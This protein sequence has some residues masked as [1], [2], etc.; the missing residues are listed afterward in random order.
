MT[1]KISCSISL[2]ATG[3]FIA[4]AG[5]LSAATVTEDEARAAASAFILADP[6]GS[7]VLRGRTVSTVFERD[8]LWIAALSPSGHVILSGSDLAD[9]IVGFSTNDFAEPDPDSPAYTYLAGISASLAAQEANGGVRHARWNRLLG[10]GTNLK[11]M[12]AA[13]ESPETVVIPPFLQ[14][15]YNQCQPYNDYVPVY[16]SSTNDLGSYRGRCPCGCVA[17][18]AAQEFRHFRWPARIDRVDSFNHSFTDTN[19]VETAFP[20]RFDG[21]LPIDWGSLEDDYVSYASYC[22]TN[23]YPGG[24]YSWGWRYDYDLRGF[25][26]ESVRYPIARLVL[27]ADVLAR[28]SFKSGSSS[29]N[30]GTVANNAS[31]WYVKGEWVDMVD[32]AERIKNDILAGVPCQVSIGAYNENNVRYKGHEVVAHGWAE[33]GSIQYLYINF[34]WGGSNDGYYNLAD[35]IQDYQEK[36]VLVGHYPR[37]KPQIDPLPKVCGTSLSLNWHFPDFYTNKLSG[38]TVS[39][40]RNATTPTTF[41]DDFSA[42]T[43]V[44]SSEAGIYV[45]TDSAGYD[46]NLLFTKPTAAGTYTFPDSYTLTSASVLTFKLYSFAALGAVYQIEARFNGGD[47][48]PLC[49]PTLKADWG[50]SGWSTERIYLGSH[51]GQTAQ[52]RIRNSHS[53]S[54]YPQD[55]SR[56]QLDDFSVTDV[57]APV[58][59]QTLTVGK[60]AR[61]ASL[62][63]FSGGATY[64]FTVTPNISG[65]LVDG[66]ASEPVSTAIAGTRNTPIPGELTYNLSTLSFSASDTSGTWSY[67]GTVVDDT[68]VGDG[69]NCSITCSALGSLTSTSTLT[70]DWTADDFY[71]IWNGADGYD[72]LSATFK[73]SDGTESPLWCITNRAA[74]TSRQ[75]VSCNLAT[76]SGQSGKIVISYSHQGPGYGVGGV[77]YAPRVANI[78]ESSVPAVAWETETLTA[79]GTP[80]IRSV[81]SV[82]EGFYSECGLGTTTFSVTC[83]ESVT[84]LQALPSHLALVGDNDVTVTPRGNGRFTVSVTPSG[85]TEDNLRSRMILTLAATDANGTTAYKD[86][87]LRFAPMEAVAAVTVTAQSA[88]GAELTAVIPYTWFIENG[89][90][91]SGA[92]DAAFQQAAYAD[93]DG[94]GMANWAE[95]V[96]QTGPRNA[97]EKLVCSIEVVDGKGKVSYWPSELRAGY[98]AVVKGTDDLRATEWTTVTTET[99]TL[100]FFKVVVEPE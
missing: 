66:E 7:A 8:G 43:G 87:S 29:A 19:N 24:G 76:L 20:L 90:A 82:S 95:Y 63:G 71:D 58:A 26:D 54:Y 48:T 86:L 2:W 41:L 27:F 18:A 57:L 70:F 79:L 35:N 14:S 23:Y 69:W 93:S 21:H 1:R 73:A 39:I 5:A 92:A 33:S 12:A 83:S 72:V 62:N 99:S 47:W 85:V 16:K 60:T 37:A 13:I 3:A 31:E 36:Q 25:V 53:G 46:G 81:S 74:K 45:T 97:D 32:G 42:S 15:H 38:F 56:I 40:S 91:S 78:L 52:F 89:L 88:S 11:L 10:G 100:H 4:L 61:S 17:T 6:V 94:D 59:P 50:A 65:A 98:R 67:S 49:T 64:S 28:M 96:C 77:I 9:P 84:S 55:E 75:Q 80:E 30:Y 22:V 44:S 68:S 34:G 51:G